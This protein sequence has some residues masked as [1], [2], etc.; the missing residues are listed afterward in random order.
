MTTQVH[1]QID[2]SGIQSFFAGLALTSYSKIL[3][4]S[5]IVH[6]MLG[7]MLGSSLAVGMTVRKMIT[8]TQ[9]NALPGWVKS[10]AYLTIYSAP[11]VGFVA[12]GPMWRN[13]VAP[14]TH[15][16]V[17]TYLCTS[18][19]CL[20]FDVTNTTSIMSWSFKIFITVFGLFGV[21]LVKKWRCFQ[22]E[23]IEEED[24]YGRTDVVEYKPWRQRML[25]NMIYACGLAFLYHAIS[26]SFLSISICLLIYLKDYIAY[27]FFNLKMNI[28][29]CWCCRGPNF[30]RTF[31]YIYIACIL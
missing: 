23:F 11:A 10:I 4:A 16:V 27:Q 22:S 15:F 21:F 19:E 12:M 5:T 13:I 8:T 2:A 14:A 7:Y 31:I 3:A 1:T 9:N 30:I 24:E 20:V 28:Y 17:N 29:S 6:S 18:K 25:A 26:N